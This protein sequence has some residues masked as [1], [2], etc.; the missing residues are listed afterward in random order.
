MSNKKSLPRPPNPRR[1]AR[2]MSS[3]GRL[4]IELQV[5]AGETA[6][7]EGFGSVFR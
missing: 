4:G 2:S 6:E 3:A 7:P 1:C 5:A